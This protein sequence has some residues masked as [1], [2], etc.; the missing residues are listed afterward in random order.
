MIAHELKA[1]QMSANHKEEM[2]AETHRLLERQREKIG[3]PDIH[4]HTHTHIRTHTHTC[5][6]THVHINTHIHT[7]TCL[8][9]RI[10]THAHICTH[11]HMHIFMCVN[12]ASVCACKCV[13]VCVSGHATV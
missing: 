9:A 10:I 5:T 7:H 6:S 12:D 2:Q 11:T 8:Q 3:I 1:A 13:S 4:T